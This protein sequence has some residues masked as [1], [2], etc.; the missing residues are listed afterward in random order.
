M[1]EYM[2]PNAHYAH[3]KVEHLPVEGILR[4]IG[5]SGSRFKALTEKLRLSYL[6]WNK[7]LNVVEVWGTE[8]AVAYG[9]PKVQK[10]VE[11]HA[12]SAKNTEK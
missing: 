12:T 5:K 4:S 1:P 11:F 3:F 10:F 8:N 9:L 6:S 7:D 2:P